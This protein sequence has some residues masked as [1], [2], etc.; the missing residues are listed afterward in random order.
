MGQ[1]GRASRMTSHLK[2]LHYVLRHKWY[3]LRAGLATG[4]P[5]W[6]LVIHD[7]SKFSPAEW[8]PYVRM[9]YGLDVGS[10][11]R[12]DSHEGI[13]G[14]AIII[15]RRRSDEARFQVSVASVRCEGGIGTVTL[16][17]E[18]G[19]PFWAYDGEIEDLPETLAAFDRAW[20]HHQ[21][22]NAHHW[23][24]WC[25]REDSGDAKVLEMPEHF[26]REMVADWMG[27]GRAITGRW[28][29]VAWYEENKARIALAPATRRVEILLARAAA[30]FSPQPATREA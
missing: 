21:H 8:S 19:D 20:L 10:V 24:H 15:Q 14:R 30:R 6:R 16:I 28:E 11:V 27:A 5:L 22:K 7:W 4:A 2:Y 29:A 17:A 9:F 12:I 13:H 26:A 25:L 18:G 1:E 23:Q 3:V